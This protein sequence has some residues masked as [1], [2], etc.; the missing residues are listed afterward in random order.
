MSATEPTGTEPRRSAGR[1]VMHTIR[2]LHLYLGL[3]LLPWSILY[4][5]TGFLFNHPTAFADA[6][7]ASF[8]RSELTGTPM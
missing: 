6:P 5:V 8:G 7:T 3:F 2:R 1:R 4:G